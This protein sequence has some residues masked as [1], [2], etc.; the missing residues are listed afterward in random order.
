MIQLSAARRPLVGPMVR[1][2][3]TASVAAIALVGPRALLAQASPAA[4]PTVPADPTRGTI[5]LAGVVR[6]TA[7][8]PLA[9]AEVR[10]G[11]RLITLTDERGLFQLRGV[12]FDTVRLVARRIGY[13][14]ASF[15]VV[16]DEPGL[17]VDVAVTLMPS[18]IA[19]GTI[20][21]E[22]VT[23]DRALWNL[24]YYDRMKQSRGTFFGPE[25]LAM[26][27]GGGHLSTLLRQVPRVELA[28]E[29]GDDYA[30]AQPSG[31]RCRMNIFIDGRYAREAMPVSASDP[32]LGLMALVSMLDVHA[33]EVYPTLSMVPVE[34]RRLGQ[35]TFQPESRAS[36]IDPTAGGG[37]TMGPNGEPPPKSELL[38][39][40]ANCG[41]VAIWTKA[42]A[43]SRQAADS[44]RSR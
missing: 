20:V 2:A 27:G 29:R 23:R 17:R 18:V 21:V 13:A 9:G 31:T 36:S 1:V 26:Y 35:A 24:G 19:L 25:D 32:G 37:M 43:G 38:S 3:L 6:D 42:F 28:N 33:V 10:A 4:S 41:A 34:F 40:D 39:T 16:A 15:A 5:T 22:G 30:Y 11:A 14:P 44:A 12:P 8:R 7:G